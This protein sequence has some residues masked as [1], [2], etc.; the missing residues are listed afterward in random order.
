MSGA[1]LHTFKSRYGDERRLI[2]VDSTTLLIEG[3]SRYTLS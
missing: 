3:P 1:L 2:S